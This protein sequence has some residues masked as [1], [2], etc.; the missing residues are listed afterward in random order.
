MKKLTEY[1][2]EE[3]LDLLADI[4][5]P[6]VAIISDP[7]IK[8]MYKTR[9]SASSSLSTSSGNTKRRSSQYWQSS[10]VYRLKILNAIS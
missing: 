2:N 10:M 1:E 9:R 7:E 6:A 8:T 5:E 3:A 4:L